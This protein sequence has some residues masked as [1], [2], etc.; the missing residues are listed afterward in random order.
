MCTCVDDDAVMETDVLAAYVVE[1]TPPPSTKKRGP[2]PAIQKEMEDIGSWGECP[3][4]G[5]Y[6]EAVG[7]IAPAN[8]L[9]KL[10]DSVKRHLQ[11]K[12]HVNVTL[13][14]IDTMWAAK[15]AKFEVPK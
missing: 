14:A 1:E 13:V 10:K 2:L 8:A 9:S 7:A 12:R 11:T 5:C 4:A 6:H 15:V 3:I